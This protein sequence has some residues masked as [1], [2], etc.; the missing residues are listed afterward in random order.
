MF[1]TITARE[2]A[3]LCHDAPRTLIDVRTPAEFAESHVAFAQSVPLDTINPTIVEAH[4]KSI[5]DTLYFV[6]KAGGRSRQACDKLQAAGMSNL[7][8]VDGGTPACLIAGLP[9]AQR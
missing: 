4:R 6:C 9:A 1:K 5:D 8:N 3:E 2:F 7:V